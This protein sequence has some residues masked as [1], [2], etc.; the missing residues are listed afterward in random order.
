[1]RRAGG[2]FKG[3]DSAL[4]VCVPKETAISNYVTASGT[5]QDGDIKLNKEGIRVVSQTQTATPAENG[6]I[7]LSDLETV[8]VLG[9]G[10]GGVV[11]LVR[12]KWTNETYALKVIHMNI[13]ETTRKQIVQE[14]TINHASQSPYVVICYHAFYTNG[15]I[16]IV[17]EYMDGGSLADIMKELEPKCIREPNLAVVSKQVLQGLMYLHQTRHIIHRDI[18]PSNLLVNH[19]GEVKISDF[20]V[21]AVLANSMGVRDTFVGTCTYMSPERVLGGTYGFDSDIW[22]LGLTLLECALG[23]YPY[24]PPGS[25]EGWMNFYELLQTIVDQPPPVA[26]ADQFS[27]EFCSFISACLQKDPKCRPSA[28]ELLNHPFVNKYDELEHGL[29]KLLPPLLPLA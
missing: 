19:K 1:M 4:R 29:A 2:K 9:K 14:L 10:S 8:K 12:H 22:S 21:S 26:P 28:A 6:N 13:E 20:G 16:S 18:K 17:L 23:Q 24:Q 3:K 15:L 5:F 7:S 25:E 11:Q 27:P